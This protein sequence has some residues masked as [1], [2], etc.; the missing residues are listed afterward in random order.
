MT[1]LDSISSQQVPGS[2]SEQSKPPPQDTQVLLHGHKQDVSTL[3]LYTTPSFHDPMV[4]SPL[5]PPVVL[6]ASAAGDDICVWQRKTSHQ[7]DR[8]FELFGS[9]ADPTLSSSQNYSWSPSAVLALAS[10]GL[11]DWH[12]SG[13]QV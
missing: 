6:M 12:A 13:V 2:L 1:T 9:T 3:A 7:F 4:F 8:R 5:E 10:V 11:S